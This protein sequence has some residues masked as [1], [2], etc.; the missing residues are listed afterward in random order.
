[1][2]QSMAMNQSIIGRFLHR[3]LGVVTPPAPTPSNPGEPTKVGTD[4]DLAGALSASP[5]LR[6]IPEEKLLRAVVLGELSLL[7]FQRDAVLDLPERVLLVMQGQVALAHFEF[8]VF[9]QERR[10]QQTHAQDKKHGPKAEYRRRLAEGPMIRKSK[11]NIAAFSPGDLVDLEADVS[12]RPLPSFYAVTPTKVLSIARSVLTDW[13]QRYP[14]FGNRCRRA[15]TITRGRIASSSAEQSEVADFYV[16]HGKSIATTMRVRDLEK[17]IEC[18]ACEKACEDRFGAQRLYLN[19]KI[20]GT[21]DFVNTC[22]TCTDQRCVEACGY[23]AIAFNVAKGEVMI[24]EDFCTGCTMC[25]RACPYDAITM[26]E[27]SETP[28]LK[29]RVERDRSKRQGGKGEGGGEGKPKETA[30]KLAS[31]CNH[32]TDYPDQACITAC[33]T[34]ALLE[35]APSDLFEART[36]AMNQA[37]ENG[38]NQTVFGAATDKLFRIDP[39]IGRLKM[40]TMAGPRARQTSAIPQL[41]I[42]KRPIMLWLWV[43]SVLAW[44]GCTAEVALRVFRPTWSLQY[45]YLVRRLGV[46]RAIAALDVVFRSSSEFGIWLG[47]IGGTLM[48]ATLIY[49]L[50][51]RSKIWQRIPL[52]RNVSPQAALGFHAWAGMMGAAF[53]VL[54]SALR[55]G[56]DL[57]TPESL[58]ALPPL[59]SFWLLV[60]VIASGLI[61]RYLAPKTPTMASQAA[62]QVK[63]LQDDLAQLRNQHAGVLAADIFFERLSR[64]YSRVVGDPKRRRRGAALLCLFYMIYEFVIYPARALRLRLSLDGIKDHKARRQVASLV[65]RLAALNRQELFA[66]LFAPLVKWWRVAHVAIAIILILL[67]LGHIGFEEIGRQLLEVRR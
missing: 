13:R 56:P 46:P 26:H 48:F 34:D 53:L 33:P 62:L 16:R 44:V 20:L 64:R 65:L 2:N 29:A 22:Q 15:S 52:L 43:L 37:A 39:F 11:R 59:I 66:P 12:A 17:C 9:A 51:M 36:E 5:L 55:L 63:A 49:S 19:G 45:Q 8:E 60:Q 14:E 57:D 41:S 54:H 40:R 21:L 18:Y 1:M 50:F 27:L 32:C 47:R 42:E 4:T 58:S 6:G 25:A 30:R 28:Q 7:S 61:G 23:D 38:Y 3:S 35:V 67:A 10:A 31:K 24:N